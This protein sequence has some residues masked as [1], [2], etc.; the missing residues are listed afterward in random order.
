[1][2]VMELRDDWSLDNLTVTER[3]DPEPGEGQVVVAMKAAT[4]NYRDY[5]MV[6]GGYGSVAGSLPLIPISDGAGEVIAVGGGV[7]EVQ[8]GDRVAPFFFQGWKSGPA[9]RKKLSR[10]LGGPLDGVMTEK[11]LVPAD[12]VV[13]VPDHLSDLEAAAYPCAG[14]TAWSAI[15]RHGQAKP[16]ETVLV[17]GTGGVSLFALQFAKMAGCKV[18][19]TSSSDEKLERLR[20]LGADHVI[21]YRSEPKWGKLAA[22]MAGGEGVDLVVEVGGG[23]TLAQ[24][25]RAVRTGGCIGLI[26][27]LGGAMPE[28]NLPLVVMRDLRLQGVTLG[29]QE[30]MEAMFAAVEQD[31]SHPVMDRTFAFEELRAA[32]E[33]MAAGRHFGKVGVTIA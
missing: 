8:V 5:L 18:I 19:A 17:Q 30:D 3:P 1:M 14:V 15:V 22:E 23:D 31:K 6:R 27:V 24:S 13:K 12:A 32:L 4:L 21:N 33:H 11:M 7:S 29:S 16:G 10:S 2:K 9:S 28:L 26:G 20:D 25:I